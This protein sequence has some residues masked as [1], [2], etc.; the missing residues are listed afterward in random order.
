[1]PRVNLSTGQPLH[2]RNLNEA[3]ALALSTIAA[4]SGI[5]S[6][7]ATYSDFD[8]S[9]DLRSAFGEMLGQHLGRP[10][11]DRELLVVPGA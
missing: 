1:M 7:L 3:V 6:R 11:A 2:D 10:V 9:P 8:G 5:A 4:S